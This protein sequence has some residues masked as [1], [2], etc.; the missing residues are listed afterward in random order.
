MGLYKYLREA[1]KQPK[2]N[3]GDFYH[4]RLILWRSEP[5]VLK[6]EKPTRLD[7]AHALGYKAKK[8][9]VVARVKLLRG[10]R[11]REFI[12]S[13][14]KS[15]NSRRKK[16]VEKSYQVV[17]EQRAQK[18]FTNLEILSS[19]FVAKDGRHFWY[20]VIMVDTARPEIKYDKKIQWICEK[21]HKKRVMRG[22]TTAGKKS[23][24]LLV[25]G[26]GAEK[27][28]PSIRANR[29]RRVRR[30]DLRR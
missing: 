13:G 17:A 9:Y 6:I 26:K 22:L 16:V 10:G 29:A 2:D 4:K 15:K 14:R 18:E 7:K 30:Y 21:Q 27:L 5:S 20:E 25:K 28:R 23:R 12:D 1:W 8:G 3:L 11:Q 24:G 19:Y